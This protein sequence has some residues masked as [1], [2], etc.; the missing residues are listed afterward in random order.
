MPTS[1]SV[2]LRSNVDIM[3]NIQILKD[4]YTCTRSTVSTLGK[5]LHFLI[6][7]HFYSL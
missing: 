4:S 7:H 2:L 5:C 3:C 1:S 6:L